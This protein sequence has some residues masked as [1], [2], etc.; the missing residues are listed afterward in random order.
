MATHT[1]KGSRIEACECERHAQGY[2][3]RIIATH[4]TTGLNWSES[5]SYHTRT[6]AE[7]REHV[8]NAILAEA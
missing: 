8:D 7:M 3:W 4:G 2:R 1:Y 6:L 5:E